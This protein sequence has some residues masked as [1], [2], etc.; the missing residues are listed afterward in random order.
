[1]EITEK[2]RKTTDLIWQGSC[3]TTSTHTRCIYIQIITG[4]QLTQSFFFFSLSS[5]L[6]V[7]V[8][9]SSSPSHTYL[10][11]ILRRHKMRGR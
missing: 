4:V 3:S 11:T 8:V 5:P 9:F 1:M 7:L 10:Y 2:G 6:P